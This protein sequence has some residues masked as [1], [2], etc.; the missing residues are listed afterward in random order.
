[1]SASMTTT[2]DT[3]NV[4]NAG[5]TTGFK[6]TSGRTYAVTNFSTNGSLGSLAKITASS[7]SAATLSKSSGTVTENFMDLSYNTASGGA[8]WFGGSG[9]TYG[10]SVTGWI[11]ADMGMNVNDALTL[12]EDKTLEIS[13]CIDKFD[14]L[15]ITED[16]T[17]AVSTG[18]VEIIGGDDLTLTESLTFLLNLADVALG[19]DL[20]LTE[21]V[22]IENPNLGGIS[23]ADDLTITESI[24]AIPTLAD[25]SQSEDITLTENIS[26]TIANLGDLAIND[27][28]SLTDEP[29]LVNSQLGDISGV[30]SLTITENIDFTGQLGFIDTSDS[31]TIT[32]S[33][34]TTVDIVVIP[35]DELTLTENLSIENSNLGG[36]SASDLLTTTESLSFSVSLS[37]IV[38]GEDITIDYT[39][40]ATIP[41]LGALSSLFDA[42]ALTELVSISNDN[43]GDI[44]TS[45]SL[46]LTELITATIGNLG[47]ILVSD[48]LTLT[49]NYTTG[50]TLYIDV[51]LPTYSLTI[52]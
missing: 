50:G 43:L 19:E 3:L 33:A 17:L 47:D 30:E 25:I 44:S 26:A 12:T 11:Q 2:I 51:P 15:T 49:D 4:N 10:A 14:S 34:L 13:F 39:T 38:S 48:E 35:Y 36:I 18:D 24:T 45:D 46:T 52:T 20:S 23:G 5:L 37:D 42:I 6:L 1:L 9:T 31:L 41:N 40:T 21:S 27:I 28:L 8:M 7:T 16:K 29:T 22:S 32:E